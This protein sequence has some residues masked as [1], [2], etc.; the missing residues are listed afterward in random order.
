MGGGGKGVLHEGVCV[1]QWTGGWPTHRGMIWSQY[2][3]LLG[4]SP[5][6]LFLGFARMRPGQP[7]VHIGPQTGPQDE[8]HQED[9]HQ[10]HH[11]WVRS[12]SIPKPGGHA[13]EGGHHTGW[14]SSHLSG[15]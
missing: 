13:E 9:D 6:L 15:A 8:A 4:W 3:N 5:G 1:T 7:V 11:E 2:E 10:E 14:S 12:S